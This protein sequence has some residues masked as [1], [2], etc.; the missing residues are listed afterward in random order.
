[1]KFILKTIAFSAIVAGLASGG[2]LSAHAGQG[3]GWGGTTIH[4]DVFKG[5]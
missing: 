3:S 2:T 5:D 1:M 4:S